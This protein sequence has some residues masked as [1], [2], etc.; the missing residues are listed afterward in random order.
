MFWMCDKFVYTLNIYILNIRVVNNSTGHAV[1]LFSLFK[2]T[3]LFHK[4]T[5][6]RS[7]GR[8]VYLEFLYP[9]SD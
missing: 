8:N 3:L 1:Y 7:E 2:S 5:I 9:A 4:V 6:H